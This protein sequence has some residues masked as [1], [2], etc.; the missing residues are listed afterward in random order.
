MTYREKRPPPIRTNIPYLEKKG[1]FDEKMNNVKTNNSNLRDYIEYLNGLTHSNG[2]SE[3][4]FH[5]MFYIANLEKEVIE[6]SHMLKGCEKRNLTNMIHNREYISTRTHPLGFKI[7]TFAYFYKDSIPSIAKTYIFSKYISTNKQSLIKN[8]FYNEIT[9]Q[10]YAKTMNEKV[11]FITPNIYSYGYFFFQDPVDSDILMT[12]YYIIMEYI[13]GVMV[14]NVTY[15]LNT[16]KNLYEKLENID[17]RLK[18]ELLSHND[19]HPRN[20]I[21]TPENELAIIDYG[22]AGIVTNECIGSRLP[23]M[24]KFLIPKV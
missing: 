6:N 9:F 13:D 18:G 10:I 3:N 5:K 20:V 8:A 12:G 23:K 24:P 17:Q 1:V 7:Q 14:R 2:T 15:N 16:Y 4:L 21:L 11:G 19:L 22:E